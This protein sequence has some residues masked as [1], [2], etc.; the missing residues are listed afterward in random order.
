MKKRSYVILLLLV[1]CLQFFIGIHFHANA[2][3]HGHLGAD[4]PGDI[5]CNICRVFHLPLVLASSPHIYFELLTYS[6]FDD[7]LIFR[8]LKSAPTSIPSRAPP[9]A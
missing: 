5:K 1:A 3:L 4:E 7:E 6:F 8:P 9:I 2:R